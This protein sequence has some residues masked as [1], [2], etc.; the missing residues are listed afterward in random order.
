M[1]LLHLF[2]LWHRIFGM[3]MVVASSL[4]LFYMDHLDIA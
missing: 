3:S 2:L 4:Q 1:Q